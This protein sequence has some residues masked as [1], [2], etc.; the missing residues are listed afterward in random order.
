MNEKCYFLGM[1]I[2]RHDWYLKE[3]LRALGK[4]QSDVVNELDW[5]KSKVSLLCNGGQSYMR[6]DVQ[7]LAAYLNLEP[8][9]LLMHPDEAMYIRR[10]IIAPQGMDMHRGRRAFPGGPAHRFR[11]PAGAAY[12]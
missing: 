6:G 11:H 3:W 8:H 12:R 10:L 7:E 1:A 9:E 5:N 4:R 2:P